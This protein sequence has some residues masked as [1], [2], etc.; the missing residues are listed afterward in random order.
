MKLFLQNMKEQDIQKLIR[1]WLK[2]AQYHLE[3]A[4]VIFKNTDAYGEA[5]F[6]WSFS[7]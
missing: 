5:L 2:G 6:F 7:N 3:K 4:E 1:Y